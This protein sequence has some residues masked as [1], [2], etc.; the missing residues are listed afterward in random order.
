M[1][2]LKILY[3]SVKF[4]TDIIPNIFIYRTNSAT[5]LNSMKFLKKTDHCRSKYSNEYSVYPEL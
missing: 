3:I 4:I 5:M 2:Y 1:K